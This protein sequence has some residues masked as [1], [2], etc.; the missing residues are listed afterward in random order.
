MERCTL[1]F[2]M[3]PADEEPV[4]LVSTTAIRVWAL[5]TS[6][7]LDT[8]QVTWQ[9]RPPRKAFV[10]VWDITHNQT[11]VSLDFECP[12][13][14]FQTFELSCAPQTATCEVDFRQ[15]VWTKTLGTV[16]A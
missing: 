7:L 6:R 4:S 9:N 8:S 16:C 5:E 10:G 11:F 14:S 1:E 2:R 13:R 15:R 12:T 3:P